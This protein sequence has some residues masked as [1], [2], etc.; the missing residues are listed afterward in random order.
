MILHAVFIKG[1]NCLK[2]ASTRLFSVTKQSN[3]SDY[4]EKCSRV[5][6]YAK[7]C[8]TEQLDFVKVSASNP[9]SITTE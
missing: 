8:N 4:T 7:C 2:V 3:C 9:S 1:T 5:L 6:K